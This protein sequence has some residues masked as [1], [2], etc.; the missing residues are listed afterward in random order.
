M[1][2]GLKWSAVF[3][4]GK[5]SGAFVCKCECVCACTLELGGET[6]PVGRDQHAMF[7]MPEGLAASVGS[8]VG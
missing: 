2:G 7:S 5:K 4:N 3:G 1:T 6:W 8:P